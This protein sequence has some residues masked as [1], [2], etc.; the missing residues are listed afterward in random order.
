MSA[1]PIACKLLQ[2]SVHMFATGRD[3]TGG[4]VVIDASVG[5]GKTSVLHSAKAAALADS[6][7]AV[8]EATANQSTRHKLLNGAGGV[9]VSLLAMGSALLDR[10]SGMRY[11]VHSSS[12]LCCLC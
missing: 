5:F 4:L 8:V 10:R 9:V 11:D 2:E 1:Q 7:L 3:G 6:R 12:S